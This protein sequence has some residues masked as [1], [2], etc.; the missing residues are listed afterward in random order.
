MARA[1]QKRCGMLTALD[2]LGNVRPCTTTAFLS[3]PH[4]GP[5]GGYLPARETACCVHNSSTDLVAL[6][7]RQVGLA[8]EGAAALDRFRALL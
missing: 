3:L 1:H 7:F 4:G 6:D 2:A 5:R 8:G